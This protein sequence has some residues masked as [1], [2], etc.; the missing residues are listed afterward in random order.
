MI[1]IYHYNIVCS[2]AL[3]RILTIIY[4]QL[5]SISESF[6]SFNVSPY[7]PSGLYAALVNLLFNPSV[8]IGFPPYF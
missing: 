1:F 8:T 4:G 5:F 6:V 2:V 3:E 7:Y